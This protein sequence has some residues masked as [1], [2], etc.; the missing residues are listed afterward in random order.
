MSKN[1]LKLRILVKPPS[2][3]RAYKTYYIQRK[4]GWFEWIDL[5]Q[6]TIDDFSSEEEV[7]NKCILYMKEYI[8]NY[9]VP[10]K[11]KVIEEQEYRIN[12]RGKWQKYENES[13][14]IRII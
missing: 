5:W 4:H 2:T 8:N 9:P 14:D 3:N 11:P 10:G 1:K 6:Q 13:N 7:Y 12:S